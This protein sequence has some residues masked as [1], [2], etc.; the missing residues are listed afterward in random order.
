VKAVGV[1]VVAASCG[2]NSP[3]IIVSNTTAFSIALD[4]NSIYWTSYDG[5]YS[6]PKNG[7]DVT[8]TQLASFGAGASLVSGVSVDSTAIYW[9]ESGMCETG[10]TDGKVMT[11]ALD[12]SAPTVLASGQACPAGLAI[13][14][15]TVYWA[16]AGAIYTVPKAGGTAATIATAEMNAL[17]ITVDNTNVYWTDFDG[18]SLASKAGSSAVTSLATGLG[19]V[20]GVAVDAA[21]VY[22]ASYN[23]DGIVAKVPIAGGASITLA[24]DNS[25]PS[26]VAVD[27]SHVYWTDTYKVFRTTLDGAS[28]ETLDGT[29]YGVSAIA[30]DD[31]DVYWG[32]NP[33]TNTVPV[34]LK[35]VAK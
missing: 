19:F 28:T 2:S 26:W 5:V 6:A 15:D 25:D 35:R 34:G 17:S 16:T 1:V 20:R 8:P 27:A 24:T 23:V 18:V 33:S 21:F 13:D 7:N 29:D 4:A 11:A 10:S 31:D 9:I 12:G 14:D 32:D 22:Y 30:L 3:A